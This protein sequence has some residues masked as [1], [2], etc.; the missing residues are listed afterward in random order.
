MH[1]FQ[2]APRGTVYDQVVFPRFANDV[3]FDEIVVVGRGA[4]MFPFFPAK[5]WKRSRRI[6]W[7]RR[8]DEKGPSMDLKIF[9]P[10]LVL[11]LS[12]QD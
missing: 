5:A 11:Y 6:E 7:G 2:G 4:L 9:L 3:T 1:A 12:R 10:K 8:I